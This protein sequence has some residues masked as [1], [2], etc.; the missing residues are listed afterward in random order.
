MEVAEAVRGAVRDAVEVEGTELFVS[1]SIGVSVNDREG[2]TAADLLRDA[3]AA[4]YRAKAR[5][6]DCV[7]AFAP[8]QPRDDRARAAHGDRA[9]PRPRARR[10]RARTSSRSSS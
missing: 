6:R 4:M 5:G 9:A 3:D 1:T 10:D 8:G 7:E 2:V